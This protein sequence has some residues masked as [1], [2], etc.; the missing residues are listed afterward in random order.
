MNLEKR[1]RL[2]YF[3][4]RNR[5]ADIEKGPA[6]TGTG[7]GRWNGLGDEGGYFILYRL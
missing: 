3:Q 4:A 2:T 5:V 6:D 1:Y 7:R